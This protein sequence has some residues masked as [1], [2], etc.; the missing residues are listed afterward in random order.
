M[1]WIF[2]KYEF[3]FKSFLVFIPI[4][5]SQILVGGV[6]YYT[7]GT[8]VV[9]PHFMYLPI[10]ISAFIFEYRVGLLTALIG[11]FILGPFMPLDVEQ[12]IMQ[13]MNNWIIRTGFFCAVG[14]LTGI[15]K[16]FMVDFY[17]RREDFLTKDPFTGLNN[18]NTFLQS[19]EGDLEIRDSLFIAVL[20]LRNQDEIITSFG[21]DFY[22][23]VIQAVVGKIQGVVGADN[24][25]Y[26]L[27]FNLIGFYSCSNVSSWVNDIINNFKKPINIDK[28]P[29]LCDVLIGIINFPEDGSSA[30]ELVQGSI[31]AINEGKK[32]LNQI[33]KFSKKGKKEFT[34]ANLINQIDH[35]LESGE[36]DFFYQPIINAKD[37]K[38]VA[39]EALIRWQHPKYGMILP[40]DYIPAL[41]ETFL[42]HE[43][44]CWAIER[45]VQ[46]ISE[47]KEFD[48]NI[49]ITVN[50]SPVDLQQNDFSMKIEKLVRCLKSD[51]LSNLTFEITERGLL[52]NSKQTLQN[53]ISI[54]EMGVGISIDD[55]GTGNTTIATFSK[56]KID[57]LKIDLD[58]VK[59][60]LENDSNKKIIRSLVIMAKSL[61]IKT[62]AEGVE[63]KEIYES[64]RS[65]GVDFLQGY[66][67]AKPMSF[68]DI[69]NWLLKQ[70]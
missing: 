26:S 52:S 38:P 50:I 27:R 58:F 6:V 19:L 54:K 11:G 60:H 42:M 36:I 65:L 17:E 4:L 8:K 37:V 10:I 59:D 33:T 23:K 62:I 30:L 13:Q 39:I 69:K 70:Q 28:I 66:Y 35:A 44:T 47:L 3:H 9:Y 31:L 45:N 21:F 24:Q 25:L 55:F 46:R 5:L 51:P 14:A 67:I 63:T 64:I 29:I 15:I 7:G 53:I 2:R 49:E 22:K 1:K 16:R 48:L 12:G 20:E 57:S 56:I 40:N 43:V 61:G 18:R 34:K 32:N 68:T 41:E